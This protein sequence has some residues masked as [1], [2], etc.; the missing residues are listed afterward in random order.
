MAW[1]SEKLGAHSLKQACLFVFL[2]IMQPETIEMDE[3]ISLTC[4][5]CICAKC[6]GL[7]EK[8]QTNVADITP[9]FLIWT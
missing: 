6:L 8:L 5:A 2:Y 3:S 9:G 7:I 1:E 4:P